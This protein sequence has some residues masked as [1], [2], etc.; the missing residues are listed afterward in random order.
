MGQANIADAFNAAAG[1]ASTALSLSD[2]VNR[3]K[4]KA[5]LQSA[6]ISMQKQFDNYIL[7]LSQRNDFDNFNVDW[8]NQKVKIFNHVSES[9][10]SPFARDAATT[11]FNSMD[12]NQQM[13]I[14]TEALKRS[15]DY[16]YT[17]IQNNNNEIMNSLAYTSEEKLAST[18]ANW[19][20]AYDAGIIDYSAYNS[21]IMENGATIAL[22]GL[23][24]GARK[25]LEEQGIEAAVSFIQTNQDRLVLANG[26][27]V[28]MDAIR[29]Q[30]ESNIKQEWTTAEAFRKM[31]QEELWSGNENKTSQVY[32]EMLSGGGVKS[33]HKGLALLKNFGSDG[34]DS[35]RRDEYAQKFQTFIDK[36]AEDPAGAA[37]GSL[38][39]LASE[40]MAEFLRLTLAGSK[41]DEKGFIN[42]ESA[43]EALKS[44]LDDEL[45]KMGVEDPNSVSAFPEL[46][47]KFYDSVVDRAPEQMQTKIKGVSDFA[48]R[49]YL[50]AKKKKK[51]G[52]LSSAQLAE[53]NS[54]QGALIEGLYDYMYT[55]DFSTMSP[56]DAQK[57][58]DNMAA[59]YFAQKYEILK[60][61]PKTGESNFQRTGGK[62]DDELALQ[63]VRAMENPEL[64]HTDKDGNV[65]F[66]PG[67]EEGITKGFNDYARK[68]IS[69]VEGIDAARLSPEWET[70]EN[71]RDKDARTIF[72][73][74]QT[75][76]KYRFT[77]DPLGALEL[78]TR[79]SGSD[80]WGKLETTTQQAAS[81]KQSRDDI[82]R[83][84]SISAGS[85]LEK[86][87]KT[88]ITKPLPGYTEAQWFSM[89]E[90]QRYQYLDAYS[91]KNPSGF[92]EWATR[93]LFSKGG[94]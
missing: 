50:E 75:G 63:A 2:A 82:A 74:S 53:L 73:D 86:N 94:L 72:T 54:F 41:G 24:D 4:A 90:S 29:E 93:S 55:T 61:N 59:A 47:K 64:V 7:G 34:L 11:M 21:R 28:P 76:K 58:L 1:F 65:R 84:K 52:D 71:G 77:T 6:E 33:A 19:A 17:T 67:V 13:K 79:N 92:T 25:V 8:E 35:Q 46:F 89:P 68:Q 18:Q 16:T 37:K 5:E 20:G 57:K 48:E 91:T 32:L 30:A 43:A 42:A 38:K 51:T 3:V 87:Q 23:Q 44:C 88:L 39:D 81:Q 49:T 85:I 60:M 62:K 31:R 36:A 45:V 70:T 15:A 10:S 78:Q 27:E 66:A 12:A 14:E 9:L 26:A 40:K 80:D 83:Q 69:T 22:G 56:A